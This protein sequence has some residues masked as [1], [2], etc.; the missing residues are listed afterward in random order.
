MI[1]IRVYWLDAIQTIFPRARE[2][3]L[4]VEMLATKPDDPNVSPQEG[5]GRNI[6]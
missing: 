5:R 1:C 4:W 2:M 6:I 3:A